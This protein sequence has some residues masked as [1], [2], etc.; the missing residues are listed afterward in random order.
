MNRLIRGNLNLQI[1]IVGVSK[2]QHL[3]IQRSSCEILFQTTIIDIDGSLNTTLQITL[4]TKELKL[5]N[6]SHIP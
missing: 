1:D 4:E 3:Q 6:T 5:K 2:D